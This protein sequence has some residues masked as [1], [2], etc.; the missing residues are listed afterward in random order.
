MVEISRVVINFAMQTNEVMEISSELLNKAITFYKRLCKKNDPD[1]VKL[2]NKFLAA[3]D[4]GYSTEELHLFFSTYLEVM[5]HENE[6]EYDYFHQYNCSKPKKNH[7]LDIKSKRQ[8][9]EIAN[10]G[11]QSSEK[12]NALIQMSTLE[13]QINQI[14]L[15][16]KNLAK[17]L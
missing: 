6:I 9:Q 4:T 16:V 5:A 2:T 13:E 3:C 1:A 14:N 10:D 15:K 8:I 11:L 7:R 17:R 12:E